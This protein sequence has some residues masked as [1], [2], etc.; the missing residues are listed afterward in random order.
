MCES[1]AAAHDCWGQGVAEAE[2]ALALL[3]P[4]GVPVSK[5]LLPL[6]DKHDQQKAR[7]L[8][9]V[10]QTKLLLFDVCIAVARV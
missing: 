10:T 2:A 8:D 3:S 6:A 4:A 9:A 5:E 1:A 7:S